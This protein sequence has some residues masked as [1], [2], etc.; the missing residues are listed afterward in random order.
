[1][2]VFFHTFNGRTHHF[3]HGFFKHISSHNRCRRVSTHTAGV[4]T[5]VAFKNTLMVLR[6]CHWQDVVAINHTN[7]RCFFTRK[8]F[9]DHNARTCIAKLVT[10]KHVINC[11]KC[12]LIGHG[13][14]YAFTCSKTISLD[15]DWR[16]IFL[17]KCFRSIYFSKYVIESRWN[18]M[19]FKEVFSE[20]FRAFKLRSKLSWTPNFNASFTACIYN[21]IYKWCFRTNNH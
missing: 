12:F 3:I 14:D 19:A 17:N 15:H 6:C 7:E 5:L 8:E 16:T 4:R 2:T 1:V 20:C 18:V 9:F 10:C 13:N 21:T 11:C